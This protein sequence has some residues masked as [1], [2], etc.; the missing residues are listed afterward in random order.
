MD[1]FD[2]M[3]F[4]EGE[5]VILREI[6]ESDAPSLS[7]LAHSESVYR[8]LPTVLYEQ[9]YEDA[10]EA[11]RRMRGE[12]FDTKESILLAI[13]EKDALG[14]LIGIAEIYALEERKPK[15]SIGCRL[16]EEWWG[17]GICTE[18]IALLKRYLIEE[19]ATRTITAHVMVENKASG[20]AC[21][22]NGFA[23]LYPDCIED[24]G[25]DEPVLVDKYVFKSRWLTQPDHPI[26]W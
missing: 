19:T 24:W 2:E 14:S 11:I 4:I 6:T 26:P 18:V 10:A 3:P 15:V 5:H 16:R 22:K 12:C 8:Y 9:K 23:K 20:R 1:P 21:L 7:K 25:F 13:C 17:R